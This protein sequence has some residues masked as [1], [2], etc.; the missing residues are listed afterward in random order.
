[1]NIEGNERNVNARHIT[2][3]SIFRQKYAN[4]HYFT[5]TQ[6]FSC[7]NIQILDVAIKKEAGTK[8]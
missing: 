4:I 1:M 3:F 5:Y 7:A 6:L 2:F 8:P